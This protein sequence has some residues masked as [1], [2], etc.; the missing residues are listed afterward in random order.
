MRNTKYI[1]A[2]AGHS[3]VDVDFNVPYKGFAPYYK[4]VDY[5]IQFLNEK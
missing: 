4:A 3:Y 2:N 1:R 5:A